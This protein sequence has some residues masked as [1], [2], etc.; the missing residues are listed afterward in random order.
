MNQVE[1]KA[2]IIKGSNYGESDRIIT[3]VTED[4]GKIK[5]IAKGARKSLKRFGGSLEP[6]TLV[7]LV[8]RMGKGLAFINDAKV[9]RSYKNI[10]N[11]LEKISFGS[12]MLELAD[13][14]SVEG[15]HPGQHMERDFFSLLLSAMEE[16]S[17][18][19]EAE[20]VVREF[21]I[22]LLSMSGYMPSLTEC[23]SCGGN[24]FQA[25]D[26]ELMNQSTAFSHSRGGVLCRD[27]SG[28]DSSSLDFISPGTLK[29]LSRLLK[30]KVSFT[31]HSLD[32]SGRLLS[33][34]ISQHA[35]KRLKSL[36]FMEHMK[37]I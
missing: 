14:F 25:K 31:R 9:V 2:L 13:A 24:V 21:Q 6:F 18:S 23:A 15:H 36:D 30:G 29:T 27:C 22:R 8:L 7:K 17:Q 35:G 11:D 16:L 3:A 5:G 4:L 28:S 12:Y 26:T 37:G 33:A 10:K 19:K 1:T 34:F 20:V 32:E